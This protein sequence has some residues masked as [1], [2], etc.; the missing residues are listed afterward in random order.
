MTPNLK[1][2]FCLA[3]AR[4]GDIGR[5][6]KRID[7]WEIALAEQQLL[8]LLATHGQVL[9]SALADLRSDCTAN[10]FNEHWNSYTN[11]AHILATIEQEAGAK[12]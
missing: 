9:I 7:G 10:D 1:E 8:A 4:Q 5:D 3:T 2:L 6:G 12:L 11:A